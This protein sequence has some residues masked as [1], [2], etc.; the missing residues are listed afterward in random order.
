MKLVAALRRH[1]YATASGTIVLLGACAFVF[2][3][4]KPHY[5]FIDRRASE[6]MPQ[7]GVILANGEFRSLEH[8]TRGSAVLVRRSDGRRLL[9]LEN[10]QTSNGPDLRV[11]LSTLPPKNDWFVY[12]DAPFVDLGAL[13]VNVGSSNYELPV[14]VDDRKYLSAVVWCVRF[15]VGFGVAPLNPTSRP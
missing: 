13:K 3:W 5:L 2:Y 9:R 7:D 8:A 12:D 15:K 1:R 11:Y 6:A 10:L 4:F 14:A